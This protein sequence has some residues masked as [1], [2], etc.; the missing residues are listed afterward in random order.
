VASTK[1]FDEYSEQYDA[2][3]EKHI[4][5][6]LAELN[7]VR[8]LMPADTSEGLEVG[9]GTGRFAVP[10]GISAGIEPSEQMAVKA[11]SQGIRVY[12]GTAEQLPFAENSFRYVLLVTAICFVDDIRA[13]FSE[14]F[15]VL[16]PE[17][18]IIVGFIDK[19]SDL[20][21]MYE[22][23][24]NENVFYKDAVFY[25]SD[26]VLSLL[27]EAGF[28]DLSSRQTLLP[29][30]KKLGVEKGFGRGAFTVISG[31]K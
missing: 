6:Y 18:I 30:D 23:H 20:G 15:R 12:R 10:L 2:W 14:V 31:K 27:K 28:T 17:G 13:S 3:F 4:D 25:S 22:A 29:G 5:L 24:R 21:R 16:K 1:P 9:V 7:A 8:Q 11:E 19:E 26:E